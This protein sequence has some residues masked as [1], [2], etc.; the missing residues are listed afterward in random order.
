MPISN[1]YKTN[2]LSSIS[3]IMAIVLFLHTIL[4]KIRVILYFL[5]LFLHRPFGFLTLII[6]TYAPLILTQRVI[7]KPMV[8]P[9]RIADNIATPF[10]KKP[11]LDAKNSYQYSKLF[12]H[13]NYQFLYQQYAYKYNQ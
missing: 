11:V 6:T 9:V 4:T 10:Y 7:I 1:R 8:K 12:Y 5:S 2:F 13:S 3:S